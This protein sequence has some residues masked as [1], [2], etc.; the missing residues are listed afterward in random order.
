MIDFDLTHEQLLLEQW[1]RERAGP[2]AAPTIHG[3][4]A[5]RPTRCELPPHR[6]DHT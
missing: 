5:D 2:D 6:E 1:V 3:S 4:R